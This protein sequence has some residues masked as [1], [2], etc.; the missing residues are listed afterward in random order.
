MELKHLAHFQTIV[1]YGN[2]TRAAEALMVAQPN[3]SRTLTALEQEIGTPLF[4][5]EKGKLVLSEAGQM[6]FDMTMRIFPD[7]DET[8]QKIRA[9]SGGG[10][11]P[12]KISMAA[13][14]KLS[15]CIAGFHRQHPDILLYQTIC[16]DSQLLRLL[17]QR[18]TDIGIAMNEIDNP[19]IA[20][21]ELAKFRVGVG[22]SRKHPLA[23]QDTICLRELREHRFVC[24]EAGINQT[25]TERICRQAGFSPKEAFVTGDNHVISMQM[26]S[27]DYVVLFP[28]EEDGQET[29]LKILRITDFPQQVTL[30]ACYNRLK[31]LSQPARALLEQIRQFYSK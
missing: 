8:V 5:R 22:V 1:Q 13:T 17:L 31:P 10:V 11:S 19:V 3:L 16:N 9:S 27:A 2:M 28:M 30:W 7:I 12:V 20:S 18:E 15:E 24:N 26:E 23:K 4:H 6:L 14:S 21:I 25:L 29:P